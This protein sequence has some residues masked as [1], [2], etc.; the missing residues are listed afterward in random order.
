MLRKSRK[1]QN[2]RGMP[3][4]PV[5][6]SPT[7]AC[8]ASARDRPPVAS[9]TSAYKLLSAGCGG[10]RSLGQIQVAVRS[11]LAFPFLALQGQP[12]RRRVAPGRVRQGPFAFPVN[13]E[14]DGA[15]ALEL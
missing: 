11:D 1:V 6:V 2:A 4:S 9:W 7:I 15:A 10:A 5:P 8:P 3:G 14:V 13:G 12:H